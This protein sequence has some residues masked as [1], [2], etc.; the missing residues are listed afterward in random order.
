MLSEL[1]KIKE[2]EI[3]Q[4]EV[5]LK[6][7]GREKYASSLIDSDSPAAARIGLDVFAKMQMSGIGNEED[8][9]VIQTCQRI[10]RMVQMVNAY[11]DESQPYHR[12]AT[13]D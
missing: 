3:E 12:M 4:L 9:D 10:T 7:V 2:R 6:S 8:S 11:L 1:I 5:S 13:Q